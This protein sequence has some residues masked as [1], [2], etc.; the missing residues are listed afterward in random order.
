MS[1]PIVDDPIRICG[2]CRAIFLED[3]QMY[4]EPDLCPHCGQSIDAAAKDSGDHAEFD[5]GPGSV[6]SVDDFRAGE[7]GAGDALGETP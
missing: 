7:S 5:Q 2:A 3:P 4:L 6:P 1:G